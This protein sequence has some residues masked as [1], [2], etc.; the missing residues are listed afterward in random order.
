MRLRGQEGGAPTNRP[1]THSRAGSRPA[2]YAP[3]KTPPQTTPKPHAGGTLVSGMPASEKE[4]R[5]L[6]RVLP[7]PSP[8]PAPSKHPN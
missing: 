3:Q 5:S 7:L 8:P 1:S 6:D 4:T 2:F